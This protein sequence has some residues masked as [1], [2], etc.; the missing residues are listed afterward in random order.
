MKTSISILIIL[1][2]LSFNEAATVYKCSKELKLDTC[3]L[4]DNSGD[5]FIY[6]VKGCSKGKKCMKAGDVNVCTKPKELLKEGKSCVSSAECQSELCQDKK[7]ATLKEGSEC[8]DDNQCGNDSY[9][10]SSSGSDNKTC[11]KYAVEG[12][13][14]ETSED[15]N[16]ECQIGFT[17]VQSG[18]N[19]KKVCVMNYS[20]EDGTSIVSSSNYNK[21][22][23][24][25]C[26][27]G[28]AFKKADATYACGTVK[29]TTSC[30]DNDKCS[31]TVS[32]SGSDEK[33]FSNLECD[34]FNFPYNPPCE[35]TVKPKEYTDYVDE[36][37]KQLAEIVKDKDVKIS[38]LDEDH[39]NNK[40]VIE[41]YVDYHYKDKIPSTDGDCVRDY[42]INKEGSKFLN[43]SLLSIF[44]SLLFI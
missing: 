31:A 1:L 21:I 17:C 42:F 13:E 40:D 7:C 14:C 43:L 36:Y 20:L 8:K 3:E 16:L 18:T 37:T 26:K 24:S 35:F 22:K 23:E 44:L 4:Y 41:K 29:T 10:K 9:C 19:T 11:A 27:S 38:Q 32:F 33:T 34:T 30:D 25:A 6:Y 12:A 39:L 28:N 2:T 5:D 15:P